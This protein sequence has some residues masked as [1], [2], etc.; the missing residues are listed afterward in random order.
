[1]CVCVSVCVCVLFYI[2]L[3]FNCDTIETYFKYARLYIDDIRGPFL[4]YVK[5]TINVHK[6]YEITRKHI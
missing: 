2:S 1:M 3:V 4:Q 5:N 6:I